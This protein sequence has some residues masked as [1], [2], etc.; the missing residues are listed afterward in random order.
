MGFLEDK[1]KIAAYDAAK[2]SADAKNAQVAKDVEMMTALQLA[3]SQKA[4]DAQLVNHG[5]AAGHAMAMSGINP[6]GYANVPDGNI[7]GY[8]MPVAQPT[9]VTGQ[10]PRFNEMVMREALAK[11]SNGGLANTM[12]PNSY[13]GMR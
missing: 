9:S 11:Q 13:Q 2:N 7:P 3:Q 1:Q 5:L 12:A 4:R 8:Q 6:N 10:D